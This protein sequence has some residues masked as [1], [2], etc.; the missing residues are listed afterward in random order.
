MFLFG[1]NQ[2]KQK[3]QRV[4]Y[5]DYAASTPVDLDTVALMEPYQNERFFNPGALYGPAVSIK[6]DIEQSR[7]QVAKALGVTADEIFFTG[8]STEA[9]QMA[10]VGTVMAAKDSGINRPT[11][12]ITATEH[13]SV[14]N[15]CLGMAKRGEIDLIQILV[16]KTG[17]V[18]LGFIREQL[19]ENTALVSV[20]YVNN[21]TGV[22]QPLREIAKLVRHHRKQHQTHFPFVHSDAV[23][24]TICSDF[25]GII[26]G[27]DLMTLSSQKIYGPKGV[28]FLY[29]TRRAKLPALFEGGGQERGYRS[30][31]ENV[32]AII[33][34]SQAFVRARENW[35]VCSTQF[36]DLRNYF[37]EGLKKINK[38]LIVHEGLLQAQSPHILNFTIPGING[39]LLVIELAERGVYVAAR[40]ACSTDD[41]DASH[42]LA[43]MY[44][45]HPQKNLILTTGSVRVSLGKMTTLA[46]VE[47]ALEQIHA[48]A[49]KY[50]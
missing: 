6:N 29:K 42:V 14:R 20:H 19:H 18:D 23:Q 27:L 13:P 3:T 25:A 5:L 49:A 15:L 30:G 31:T 7:T 12:M 50:L 2:R 22:M 39:E 43:A 26:S 37:L 17:I 33:G 46:D 1:N 38:Q 41:E 4:V 32:A 45:N 24:A 11:V 48:V 10:I 44:N 36:L 47:Y 34:G 9:N 28:G 21:E 8:G 35:P 16:D 40:A